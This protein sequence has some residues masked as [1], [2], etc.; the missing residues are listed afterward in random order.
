MA[1]RHADAA[2][3]AGVVDAD[4]CA[5][6]NAPWAPAGLVGGDVVAVDA[7][8]VVVVAAD[9]GSAAPNWF[10]RL[11]LVDDCDS[12][13]SWVG[14]ASSGSWVSRDSTCRNQCTT[15]PTP[16]V[17]VADS[18]AVVVVADAAVGGNYYYFACETTRWPPKYRPC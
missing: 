14:A 5:W 8:A 10:V 7:V 17:V 11:M 9:G 6:T 18:V 16:V 4:G 15:H 13:G 2:L 1:D 12:V 3:G